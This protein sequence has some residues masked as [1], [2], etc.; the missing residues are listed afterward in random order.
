MKEGAAFAVV[1]DEAVAKSIGKRAILVDDGLEALQ[2]L[3]RH[4]RRQLNI[5][6]L[7]ITGSNGKTTTK[8]L[9]AAVMAKRYRVHFTQGNFNNHIGLP[10]TILQIGLEIEVA[11]LEMG[12]NHQREI[13][14]LCHIAEPSHGLITNIGEAHLEGFGGIEGVKKGKGELYDFLEASKGIAFVN[15][16]VDHLSEMAEQLSRR[17]NYFAAELPS[18]TVAGMEVKLL[19]SS[20]N[21]KVAFLSYEGQLTEATTHLPGMHNFENVKAAIAVGKYFKVPA[22]DI[23]EALSEY[24]AENNRSQRLEHRGLPFLLDAYNAN[25]SSTE[26]A[27]RAFV[28]ASPS[29]RVAVLGAMLELGEASS[30]AHLRIATLALE[31][32]IEKVVLVGAEYAQAAETLHLPHFADAVAAKDWF[33]Q[34]D[35]TNHHIMLKAS[36]GVALEQL[37]D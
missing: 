15:T 20:P 11:I 24:K 32:G 8:E 28:S 31:L 30:S 23:A 27:L 17:V 13:A 34:Q 26:A 37:I 10:L 3:A 5:P 16:D 18:K 4:H 7:A 2:V 35:W 14:L 6:V 22:Q 33:W 36:R 12:A 29:P 9:I 25:P 19:A 1:D 21:V